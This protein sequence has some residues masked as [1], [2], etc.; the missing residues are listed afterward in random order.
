MD[1]LIQE[2][3]DSAGVTMR[4]DR[5]QGVIRGVKILGIRSRN[6]REYLPQALSRAVPLYENAKVNVNHPKGPP[7]QV[8]DYQER[9]GVIRNVRFRPDEGLFADLYFNP[10]HAVAEQLIWD[11]EHMP[12]N[13]GFSHNVVART[14]RRGDRVVVEAICRV[15]SVDL[16]ADPATTSGLFE[17]AAQPASDPAAPGCGNVPSGEHQQADRAGQ[18]ATSGADA[19]VEATSAGEPLCEVVPAA[20]A[21][22]ALTVEQLCRSRPDLV[23][24]LRCSQQKRL[25]EL[26][27]EVERLREAEAR[28]RRCELVDRLLAEHGLPKPSEALDAD[29]GLVSRRFYQSLLKAENEALV[30]EMIRE[31]AAVIRTVRQSTAPLAAEKPQSRA[32]F[33]SIGRIDDVRAFV[34]AITG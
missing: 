24:A 5:R 15:Q 26:E 11:A 23:E 32:Q 12:E 25:A 6:G 20:D 28:Y 22:A 19:E 17:A 18:P 3:V 10:K 1:Q 13:V 4:V 8:R 34:E 7:D 33:S 27:A 9:L 30:R 21:L 31:R 2:Y 14:S 29:D 16:V